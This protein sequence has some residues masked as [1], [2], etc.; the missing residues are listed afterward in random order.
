MNLKRLKKGVAGT[1]L[2]FALTLG[3]GMILSTTAQA[4]D[5]HR[6]NNWNRDNDRN[7]NRDHDNHR[8]GDWQRRQQIDR[9]REL[10]RIRQLE[11]ERSRRGHAYPAPR[12]YSNN[13]Y[14]GGGYN[15]G[16]YSNGDQQRGF[17][18]GLD[19]GQEDARDGRSFTPNNSD[20]FRSGDSAYRDGFRRG[21]EQGYRQNAGYRRR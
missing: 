18:D 19:R 20:H 1:A 14:Y 15:G 5:R 9:A 21:Y 2:M 12:V 17:S 13:G 6:D 16:R 7:R 4:Q 10:V 8:D 11:R 3:S